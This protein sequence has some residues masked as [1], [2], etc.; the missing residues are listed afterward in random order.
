[1]GKAIGRIVGQSILKNQLTKLNKDSDAL[2][3]DDCGILIR[4]IINAVSLFVTKEE[5]ETV[6]SELYRIL[7]V[8]FP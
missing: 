4:N 3:A 2:S 1:M 5:V 7:K 8:H 6:H